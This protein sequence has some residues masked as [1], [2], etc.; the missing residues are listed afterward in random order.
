[1]DY[2]EA[3]PPYPLGWTEHAETLLTPASFDLT[4]PTQT[5]LGA[6]SATGDF[7]DGFRMRRGEDASP[8]EEAP[9]AAEER[10]EGLWLYGGVLRPHYGHFLLESLSR[11][12]FLRRHPDLPVL[13]HTATGKSVLLPW[14]REVFSMLGI[15][16]GRCRFVMRPT[17]VERILL[18]DPGCVLERWL[19]P[20]QARALGIFP[21]A[22]RPVRERKVWLSRSRLRDGLAK[23]Q[24]EAELEARLAETGWTILSPEGLPVWQ[25]LAVMSEAKEIAGFEGSAFHTLLLAEEE[26]KA[27]VTL[28]ARSSGRWPVMHRLIAV[29]K[30]LRQ[31]ARELPLRHVEGSSRT[32]IVALAD[33]AAAARQVQAECDGG[34]SG[35]TVHPVPSRSGPTAAPLPRAATGVPA[36]MARPLNHEPRRGGPLAFVHVPKCGGTSFTQAI[37]AGWPEAR[38]VATQGALDAIPTEELLGLDLIAGHFYAHRLAERTGDH[39]SLVTVLRDPF[40]RLFSAYR[41]GREFARK[42]ALVGPAM[43][44]AGEVDFGTW[45]FAPFGEAQAHA[46]LYQLGLSTGDR[47]QSVPLGTLLERAKARLEGMLVGTVDGLEAFVPYVFRFHDRGFPP[48]VPRAMATSERYLPEEAGLTTDQRMALME[49]LEP[50]YAFYRHGR[51]LMLRRLETQPA[52]AAI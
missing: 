14:H 45:A 37:R 44:L 12:W 46:Q 27:R 49:R 20:A 1:V 50:D 41:F 2:L 9:K 39:F 7:L 30:H 19:D 31:Y 3:L 8:V 4:V 36:V 42:G 34:E 35:A 51:D 13:W 25:Q 15:P 23:V 16:E 17:Q 5:R 24:G 18:A 33:P 11:A 26:V 38:V 52:S 29:T 28:Y 10:L 21:L 47:A 40:E 32:Q 6:F 43:R 22:N 48:P